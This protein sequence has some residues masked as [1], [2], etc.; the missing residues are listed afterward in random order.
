[1]TPERRRL[2]PGVEVPCVGMGTWQT[3]DVR[4][5][6]QEQVRAQIVEEALGAGVRVFDSSPMYG[7]AERLLGRLLR[8]RRSEV[9]V[10]T[11][12]WARTVDEGRHQ[13]DRAIAAAWT[14]SRSPTTHANG[15]SSGRSC[16]WP[17]SSGSACS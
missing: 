15:R 14:P 6:A 12:I 17:T 2:A 16:R 7:H 9:F 8:P 5:D 11:K 13:A 1:L 10:A 4:G 3:F